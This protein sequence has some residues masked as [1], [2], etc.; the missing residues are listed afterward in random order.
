MNTFYYLP[1][2]QERFSQGSQVI[3]TFLINYIAT[4]NVSLWVLLTY[5]LDEEGEELRC[6]Q[7]T[8]SGTSQTG[9]NCCRMI[10]SGYLEWSADIC[11]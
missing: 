2:H 10:R 11:H 8:P 6:V 5:N 7:V 9:D 3:K 4:S 1:N